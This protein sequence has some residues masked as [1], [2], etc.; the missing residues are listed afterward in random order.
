MLKTKIQISKGEICEA[1]KDLLTIV[2][3]DLKIFNELIILSS[4]FYNLD[5]DYNQGRISIDQILK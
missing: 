1:I 2:N 5:K 3:P 4:R